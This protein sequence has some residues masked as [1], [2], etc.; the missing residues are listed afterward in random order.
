MHDGGDIIY[1]Y[2]PAVAAR[3]GAAFSMRPCRPPFEG[4]IGMPAMCA[5]VRACVCVCVCGR[6]R[7]CAKIVTEHHTNPSPPSVWMMSAPAASSSKARATCILCE[8][9]DMRSIIEPCMCEKRL[10]AFEQ[11]YIGEPAREGRGC[12][13]Q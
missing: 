11:S 12:A 6:R 13:G 8:C 1:L 2:I 3:V 5:C 4:L 7:I 9:K 10:H